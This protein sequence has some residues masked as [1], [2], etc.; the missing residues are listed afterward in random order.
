MASPMFFN[1]LQHFEFNNNKYNILQRIYTG[2][3]LS[4][5]E[6][7]FN[8]PKKLPNKKRRINKTLVIHNLVFYKKPTKLDITIFIIYYKRFYILYIIIYIY[9]KLFIIKEIYKKL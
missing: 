3:K 5:I 8:W 1:I 9:Y 7:F 2:S 4:K 6:F